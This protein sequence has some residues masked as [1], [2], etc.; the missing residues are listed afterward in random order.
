M[1]YFEVDPVRDIFPRL[2]PPF[3]GIQSQPV[4]TSEPVTINYVTTSQIYHRTMSVSVKITGQCLTF[5]NE[6]FPFLS[7]YTSTFC[8]LLAFEIEYLG[9]REH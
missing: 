3:N 1:G 5:T 2:Q 8:S 7:R 4:G 9:S 6:V